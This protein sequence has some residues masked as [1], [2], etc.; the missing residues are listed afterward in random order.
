MSEKEISVFFLRRMPIII[1]FAIGFVSLNLMG[2]GS[3]E[4]ETDGGTKQLTQ[5]EQKD[6]ARFVEYVF[7]PTSPYVDKSW[8]EIVPEEEVAKKS[9]DFAM[10]TAAIQQVYTNVY[11]AANAGDTNA[12]LANFSSR[13]FEFRLGDLKTISKLKMKSHWLEDQSGSGLG[14]SPVLSEF[15][16]RPAH[17]HAPYLEASANRTGV[18]IYLTKQVG[19]WSIHQLAINAPPPSK[20]FTDLKY[21]AP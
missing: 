10:E 12:V 16:I 11:N 13:G 15:Y 4:T 8:I 2:C 20:Y 7:F 6:I 1:V 18:Y 9:I 17:V 3:D 19:K 14:G 21:K 5:E